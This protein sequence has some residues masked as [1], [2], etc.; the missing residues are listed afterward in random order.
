M[1][2][3]LI[4][5]SAVLSMLGGGLMA[6]EVDSPVIHNYRFVSVGYGYLHDIAD[7]GADGHGAVGALSFEE[8]NFLLGV[9]GGYFWVDE[10]A[11]DINLWSVAASIGY[12][13]R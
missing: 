10:D 6:A 5:I 13:V 12:V 1:R 3:G 9:G 8:Q 11:A 4:A 2:N 7:S